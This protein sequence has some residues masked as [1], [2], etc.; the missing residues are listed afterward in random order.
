MIENN[1]YSQNESVITGARADIDEGLRAHM[2]RV[3]NAMSVGLGV[4]GIVAA[5]VAY[6]ATVS[7]EFR[8]AM[9]GS[10]LFYVFAFAPLA[11][12]WFGM[13]PRAMVTKTANQLRGRFYLFASLMGVSMASLFLVFTGESIVRVFFI[14]AA[15]FLAMSLWGYTTKK[16]LTTMG[17]FLFMG[18]IGIVIASIVNIFIGSAM[19]HWVTSVLGVI[20]FT[21]M[22][23]WDTQRIKE[24]YMLS[25]GDDENAKVAIMGALSL[26]LNFVLLFQSLLNILGQRN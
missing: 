10:P 11:F 21:G 18:L 22:T 23:A 20:I 16:D 5:A 19:I 15:T 3:Y 26:Y 1:R 25:R 14:T 8:N 17:S 7:V 13:G 6:F 4:T 9:F 12:L 2:V 24:S